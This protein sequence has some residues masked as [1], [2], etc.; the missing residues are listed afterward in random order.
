MKLNVTNARDANP[1]L[2]PARVWAAGIPWMRGPCVG[3]WLEDFGWGGL[4]P[5]GT[6]P[7]GEGG[8][9]SLAAGRWAG[10]GHRQALPIVHTLHAA[11]PSLP[12]HARTALG[13]NNCGNS[14]HLPPQAG[15][16]AAAQACVP[17]VGQ[18]HSQRAWPWRPGG[19]LPSRELQRGLQCR[20]RTADNE[21]PQ[22]SQLWG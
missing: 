4:A 21:Q 3:A 9:Q 5:Q 12:P 7:V 2:L 1:L 6:S 8:R 13:S 15:A 17:P 19:A 11:A 22:Q 16:P 20:R 14:S 18:L 10:Q